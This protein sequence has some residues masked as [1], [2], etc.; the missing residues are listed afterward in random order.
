M[1]QIDLLTA[2]ASRPV[3]V[4]HGGCAKLAALF[5]AH[6]GRRFTWR[7]LA[8]VGG[9]A[10]WRTRVSQ[11]R[12]APWRMQIEN[13]WWDVT[14]QDGST[15]RESVYW[16][17]PGVTGDRPANAR[18]ATSARMSNAGARPAPAPDPPSEARAA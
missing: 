2:P 13:D 18:S 6:P 15:Y 9:G 1:T 11:L 17:V 7:E 4:R 8:A 12:R 5:R 16:Y 10:G 14:T 3:R